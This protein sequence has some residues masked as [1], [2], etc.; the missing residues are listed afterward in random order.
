MK[1]LL[2]GSSGMVGTRLFEV[3]LPYHKVTGLDVEPNKWNP[4]L[5]E[6]TIRIDLMHRDN[7][8]ILPS[9][10]DLV[11]H[12]AANARVYDL[13][14]EPDLAL[15]NII[16]TFNVL[17][18]ARNR[19]IK[20]MMFASSREAY[21][22]IM[23]L[24]PVSEDRV[25][26]ENCE[27]PYSASKVGG[28]A[29]MQAYSKVYGLETVIVRFSN[30]YGM[31]DDSDRV[32]PLWIRKCLKGEDLIAFGEHKVL[33]FTYI[34]DAVAGVSEIINRFS[35]VAGQTFNIA[36]GKGTLLLNV[37]Q[38]IQKLLR[39]TNRILVKESRPGEVWKYQ[40]D[41]SKARELLSYRPM[42][43]LSEGLEKTVEWYS[44]YLEKGYII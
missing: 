42:V 12:F 38:K 11:I 6:S 31:Y 40:A 4:K 2:T 1:I 13:V 3:L 16:M 23:L 30:V 22:N 9:D 25:Q 7:L 14:T 39:A 24:G 5:D 37:A 20:R 17:E 34:D 15:E 43:S 18:F 28:E 19:G 32:I 10:Y 21:G 35:E 44:Q 29:M 41:I 33:D 36:S 27:S 8:N 26:L